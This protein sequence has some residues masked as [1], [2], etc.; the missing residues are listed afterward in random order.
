MTFEEFERKIRAA[1]SE[2]LNDPHLEVARMLESEALQFV[3]GNFR[4]Q[5]W[6]GVPWKKSKGTVLVKTGRLRRGFQSFVS[7]GE[8]RIVNDVPYARIHNEG[9]TGT[10]AVR[11]HTRAKSVKA[12]KGLRKISSMV[13]VAAHQRTYNM[14]VRQFAPVPGFESD[15]LRQSVK[16][17]LSKYLENL[18]KN[19]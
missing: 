10:S 18:F 13:N 11:Q 19:V 2:V 16:D 6:E 3:D 4:N 12:G 17:R 7:P 14:P 5:G 1:E 8:A 9:L 15:T